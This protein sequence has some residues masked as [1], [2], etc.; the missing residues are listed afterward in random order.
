MEDTPTKKCC[1]NMD[2]NDMS[3]FLS[4]LRGIYDYEDFTEMYSEYIDFSE[5]SLGEIC[6]C[7]KCYTCSQKDICVECKG[8]MHLIYMRWLES[9]QESYILDDE[10]INTPPVEGY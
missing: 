1:N 8:D 5:F 9:M 6:F 7:N 3:T 10:E 4:V 2:V